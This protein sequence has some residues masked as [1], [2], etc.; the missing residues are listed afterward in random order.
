[1]QQRRRDPG[2]R[3]PDKC[4]VPV[5]DRPGAGEL[6]PGEGSIEFDSVVYSYATGSPVLKGVSF[7]CAG[8]QTLALVGATGACPATTH[9]V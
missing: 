7:A 1:M 4:L 9:S 6:V 5:Q 8:G 2:R 3:H